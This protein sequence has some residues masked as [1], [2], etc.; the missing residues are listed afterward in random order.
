M[1][2]KHSRKLHGFNFSGIRTLNPICCSKIQR[3]TK[4]FSNNKHTDEE[5]DDDLVYKN[6]ISQYPTKFDSPIHISSLQK[7]QVYVVQPIFESNFG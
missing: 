6:F 1:F 7:Q 5:L 2:V 3:R 4:Y